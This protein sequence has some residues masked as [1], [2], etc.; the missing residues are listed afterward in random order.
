MWEVKYQRNYKDYL[1]LIDNVQIDEVPSARYAET[2]VM[3][4]DESGD[5]SPAV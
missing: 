2:M 3:K 4:A 1:R 5:C